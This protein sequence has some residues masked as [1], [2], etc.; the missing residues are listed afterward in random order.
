MTNTSMSN[1]TTP[2]SKTTS[3]RVASLLKAAAV[4][5]VS[6]LATSDQGLAREGRDGRPQIQR[7]KPPTKAWDKPTLK[8]FLDDAFVELEGPRPDFATSLQ[9]PAT[10]G[11]QQTAATTTA[12]AG[13]FKWSALVS[14]ETLTDEIKDMKSAVDE[15]VA[16]ASDFKGGGY[17]KARESFSVVALAFG[18][19]AA[20][21]EDIR[22]KK[23]AAT[24]RDLFARVGSNCKVGT[25]QSFNES[26]LRFA[27]LAALLEGT[28]PAARADREEDFQWSQVA[29]RSA[30]MSRLEAAD[31]MLGAAIASKGEF[32][33]SLDRLLREAEIVA[34]IGEAI[35][36]PDY[37]YHDD[38]TYRGYAGAMR[39]AA[40]KTREA[41]QKKDYEAARAA[42]G[43]MKKSCDSCHGDYRS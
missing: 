10:G 24:A 43:A 21:D 35:Q 14:E 41:V 3:G 29:A 7:A 20:Y 18:V 19:I 36:Q 1:T 6:W 32:D 40:V 30:L 22:W 42:V 16:S 23:D 13:G 27:D 39:D 37:E 4:V 15:A 28:S 8:T 11:A 2:R 38:D 25:D 5:V 17:D 31:G 9:S 12:A 33:K 26:K 34:V